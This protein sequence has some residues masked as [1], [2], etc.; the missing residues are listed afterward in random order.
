M[1]VCLLLLCLASLWGDS[2]S[3]E[4]VRELLVDV[5][6]PGSDALQILSPG[7]L[8]CQLACTQHHSCLF[9]TF[10]RPDWTRDKRQF[11]C[12]L[13]H[14]T[15]GKP[16]TIKTLNGV[17][18]GYS[19]KP[20]KDRSSQTCLSTVYE[21]VD[22][23]G[24][25]YTYLFTTNYKDCQTACTKDSSCQFFTFLNQDFATPKYRNKCYL[26]HRRVFPSP[27]RV[28]SL[29]GV[30]SGFSHRVCGRTTDTADCPHNFLT[31]TNFPGNDFEQVRAPSP[32]YCH[33]LCNIHPRCT[34]YSYKRESLLCFLKHNV[35]E[36]PYDSQTGVT[37]GTPTRFCELSKGNCPYEIHE[38][39]DFQGFDRRYVM[40]DDPQSCLET[41][42]S[43][44]DCQFY[45]YV[46]NSY[47]DRVH[48][49][50]CYLKQV[51]TVPVPP[52]VVTMQGVVSGFHQR[53]CPQSRGQD[54][55]I[56]PSDPECVSE[57]LVDVDFPGTDRVQILSPDALHCQLAC[58][59]HHDCA[60]FTFV[61]PDWTR[62]KRQFYCYLKHTT[63]GK[64]VT[65]KT[66]NGVTSGYSLKLC[67]DRSSQT[68]L[69][70][71]YENVD[72]TGADYTFL[73]TA[74]YKDCQTAC[75]K[76][77]SCQFFTF[78]NQD[79]PMPKYRNKCCL[80][81]RR[82]FPSPPRVNSLN[83][84]V[85]GF[86]HR[87]CSGRTTDTA[88]CPHNFLN[89]TNFPGNDLEAVRA[90]SP[91][92][93]HFLCN[94][95]PHCTFYSYER[96]GLSCNLKHNVNER[97]Y[98]SQQGVTSGTPTRFCELSKG[99]CPYVTYENIDFQGF[100]ARYV[101]LESPQ[102]C[103]KACN[104]D[105]DCQFYAYVYPSFFNAVQRKLCY[106]KQVITVPVPPKVVTM[107]GVV[108]GF[109]K[110]GCPQSRGQDGTG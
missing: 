48:R 29:K 22:F 42:N 40:L 99:N 5:D 13:K 53:D 12:Y 4:C 7:A 87:V 57:L 107:Q 23:T 55:T 6:F 52:K 62:D 94:I 97:H 60:F 103:Q 45:T 81:H 1:R 75:T 27:P 31:N 54:R 71:V 102:S 95:H 28:N 9:F 43:D 92:Y 56:V 30:T 88:D 50:R 65:I 80:K 14:T 89:N 100:E 76:D 10:V 82:V 2:L 91:E 109:H 108:S 70:T 16:V 85:S 21:N 67:K 24:A 58:T 34:F 35:D 63:S 83:D 101:T 26:K 93:C 11:Y 33:F 41:C 68:C 69:S 110:R 49:R 51:I 47:S 77:S 3:E 32:E 96:E 18:S 86:S 64:P 8:H 79:F 20:C 36:R 78:L 90:P 105:P 73:F 44:P 66:L 98:I 17:T 25:D 19:L 38:D 104:K 84:V 59:Q 61:R 39:I 15:S 46:H 74:N 37:S 106:L 72:F